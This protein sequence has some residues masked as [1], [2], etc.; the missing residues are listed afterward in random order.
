MSADGRYDAADLE[1]A[2]RAV[3]LRA[4][5]LAFTHVGLGM[6]G[7]PRGDATAETASAHVDEAFSRVLGPSGTLVVPTYSYTYTKPGEI[8]DPEE[9][10]SDVGPFTNYFRTLPDVRRSLD[11]IFSVAARG[12]L[13]DEL[14]EH[15]PHDCFGHDSVYERLRTLDARL[16]N[17]GVG[18]RYATFIHHVEQL[19]RVP[20]RFPKLFSGTTRVGGELRE[21]TWLYNVRPLELD[22]AYPDLRRLEVVARE[23]GLVRSAR[24]GRGEVTCITATEMWALCEEH[25]AR[26]PW[27]MARG[28]AP[29]AAEPGVELRKDG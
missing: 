17:V 23:R 25:V 10:P 26:D 9:T 15:L 3:G 4:G 2:V 5:D 18:F 20:Y 28:P 27:F 1:Q 29:S 11:P 19:L 16:L 13:A 7:L 24:A 12:P 22:A 21:E 6:L 14:L 8:Y